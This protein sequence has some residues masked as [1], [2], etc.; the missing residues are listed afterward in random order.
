MVEL[1]TV[2][3]GGASLAS[4]FIQASLRGIVVRG[5]VPRSPMKRCTRERTD[6]L[7]VEALHGGPAPS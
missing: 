6:D 7:L 5:I 2:E 4:D 1:W 3:D